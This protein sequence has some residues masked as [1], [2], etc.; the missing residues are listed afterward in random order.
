MVLPEQNLFGAPAGVAASVGVDYQLI[1]DPLPEGE[2]VVTFSDP[3]V[4]VTYRLIVAA[5]R[6]AEPDA[7]PAA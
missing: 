6:I 3:A 4:T 1:L 5:P 7:T 2:H